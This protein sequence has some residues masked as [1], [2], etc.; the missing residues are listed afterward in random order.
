MF[1]YIPNGLHN[2]ITQ[3]RNLKFRY[4]PAQNLMRRWG[5][6]KI[7]T[8]NRVLEFLHTHG[9]QTKVWESAYNNGCNFNNIIFNI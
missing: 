3:P 5:Q 1:D 6:A 9:E 2:I 7:T 4:S 8:A